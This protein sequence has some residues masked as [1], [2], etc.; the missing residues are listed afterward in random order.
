MIPQ[1]IIESKGLVNAAT[2]E[3]AS[4]FAQEGAAGESETA[5]ATE[6]PWYERVLEYLPLDDVV[7]EMEWEEE[8]R[9]ARSI[10]AEKTGTFVRDHA[11]QLLQSTWSRF[12]GATTTL[13]QFAKASGQALLDAVFF[14]AN[15]ALFAVCSRVFAERN[16]DGLR[17]VGAGPCGAAIIAPRRI[18]LVQKD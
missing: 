5:E 2:A 6:L 12:A 9:S 11:T 14:L 10:V 8:G 7:R 1:L 4:E 18:E 17:G 16:F 15:F 3:E 13:A